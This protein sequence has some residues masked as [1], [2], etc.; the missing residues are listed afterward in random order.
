MKPPPQVAVGLHRLLRIVLLFVAGA[1]GTACSRGQTSPVA[2]ASLPSA[3]N[4]GAAASSPTRTLPPQPVCP[5]A[6]LLP[7]QSSMPGIGHHRVTLTWNASSL[8]KT[9]GKAVGYCLYRSQSQHI[10]KKNPNCKQCESVNQVPVTSLS[11]VDDL[12]Q[13]STTYYYVVTGISSGSRI[14]SSSNEIPAPIP[15]G[16]QIRPVS[17]VSSPAPFCREV[18]AAQSNSSAKNQ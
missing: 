4:H 13:D 5:P 12:V 18:S 15:G 6:G 16:D 14:S 8:G 3:T 1:F 2:T 9:G 7:L 10:A 17:S 11:C